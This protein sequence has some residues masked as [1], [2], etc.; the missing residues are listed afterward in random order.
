MVRDIGF[1]IYRYEGKVSP[2]LRG[3]LRRAAEAVIQADFSNSKKLLKRTF[4][5]SFGRD[6]AVLCEM[7][8]RIW[9]EYG[10]FCS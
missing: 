7:R 5:L 3:H 6:N 8:S 4:R 10:Y 1:I 2:R 9:E